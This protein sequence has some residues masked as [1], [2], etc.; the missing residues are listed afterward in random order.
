MLASATSKYARPQGKVTTHC[1]LFQTHCQFKIPSTF[2][3]TFLLRKLQ[4]QTKGFPGRRA[5]TLPTFSRFP[6]NSKSSPEELDSTW[7]FVGW[8][9]WCSHAD[10]NL[11]NKYF[12]NIP[13]LEAPQRLSS[14][15][16]SHHTQKRSTFPDG[17]LG[18]S[19]KCHDPMCCNKCHALRP[20]KAHKWF[21]RTERSLPLREMVVGWIWAE[22]FRK[23]TRENVCQEAFN[24]ELECQL[25]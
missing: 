1:Y 6:K 20:S 5:L 19:T 9:E 15:F 8:S 16:S 14:V 18:S 21:Q 7:L 4:K 11:L 12:Q 10:M 3:C 2:G 22:R 23:L 25:H 17:S 24:R 13:C